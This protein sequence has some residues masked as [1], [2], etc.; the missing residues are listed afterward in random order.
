MDDLITLNF[1][2]YSLLVFSFGTLIGIIL[3]RCLE[4]NKPIESDIDGD[5]L[6]DGFYYVCR[7]GHI[8]VIKKLISI[9]VNCNKGLEGACNGGHTDIIELLI[10]HGANDWNLGLMGACSGDHLKIAQM[11]IEF[12]AT[13]FEG[14]FKSACIYRHFEIGK[15]I[16][17][18][19]KPLKTRNY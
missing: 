18:H 5:E 15:L 17:E 12:G 16:L 14:A 11:M 10:R 6:A 2:L 1:V 9:G 3:D 7:A 4:K 8:D 13:D 19:M